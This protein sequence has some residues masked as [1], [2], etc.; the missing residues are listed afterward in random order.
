MACPCPWPPQ[1]SAIVTWTK[2]I[3]GV[4]KADPDVFLKAP[5]SNPGPLTELNFWVERAANLNSVH[6][7][8][9]GEKIQKVVRVLEMA[10][11]TYFPAFDRCV[12]CS[13]P[14]PCCEAPVCEQGQTN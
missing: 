9:T 13:W 3:K 10:Q 6:E 4:L 7:Q 2:Q 14:R 12:Y 8:L 1:E 11:S 5:H